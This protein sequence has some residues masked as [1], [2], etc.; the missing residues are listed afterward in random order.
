MDSTAVEAHRETGNCGRAGITREGAM[1]SNKNNILKARAAFVQHCE[2]AAL[3]AV[4]PYLLPMRE[5]L[6][7]CAAEGKLWKNEGVES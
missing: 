4:E 3:V 1:D 7:K 2:L 5:S 6:L